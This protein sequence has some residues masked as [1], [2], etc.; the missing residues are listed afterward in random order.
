[1]AQG[2]RA[3]S[4][5]ARLLVS[6]FPSSAWERDREAPLRVSWK[7]S[8]HASVAKHSFATRQIGGAG[9]QIHL[10]LCAEAD[11]AGAPARNTPITRRRVASS[12]PGAI[13]KRT[14]SGNTRLS[15]W[16]APHAAGE[17][18]SSSSWIGVSPAAC[19]AAHARAFR[20][21]G[22]GGTWQGAVPA[23][24]DA[25]RGPAIHRTVRR[26]H[27]RDPGPGRASARR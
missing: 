17:P 24:A 19:P 26:C 6:S 27:P 5:S 12:H 11:H 22:P 23:R 2:K 25:T 18:K 21:P 20:Y 3:S 16:P 9:D 4:S 15:A 14:P 8:F 1:M 10:R 13:S 7:Q